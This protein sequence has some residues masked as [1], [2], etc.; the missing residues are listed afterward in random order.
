MR[1]RWT[2]SADGEDV[3]AR[4]A[5]YLLSLTITDEAGLESDTLEL[6]IADPNA[7]IAI[8]RLGAKLSVALGYDHSGIAPMGDFVVD[9]VEIASP[10]RHLTIRA[11][12][13]DLR[14]DTKTRKTRA[15]E[16]Q[17]LGGI[18]GTVSGELA[19]T[20]AVAQDLAPVAVAR[21]DQTNEGN[22][23]FLTRL[24]Q[25]YGAIASPKAGRLVF[26]KRGAATAV[27][28]APLGEI[29]LA[30]DEVT[31]WRLTLTEAE[32]YTAVEARI[33]DR[34][35][36]EEE[37]V[38][39]GDDGEGEGTYRLRGTFPDRAR[40]QAAAEAKLASKSREETSMA[41]T[42]PGRTDIGAETPVNLA[43]FSPELDGRWIIIRATHTLDSGGYVLAVE[44]EREVA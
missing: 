13:A 11:H 30:P 1:P 35:Q 44:G 37:W 24:A 43:G 4:L 34:D 29:A 27:S 42:L 5:D 20:P 7:A 6:Q 19:L 15:F 40:A 31:D 26:A 2:I 39:A 28:G 14:G 9:T 21:I 36:A 12:A 33:Y 16:D 8:P 25:L 32:K 17:T 3:T 18:V 22:L 41:L 10:P 23:S 38:Q